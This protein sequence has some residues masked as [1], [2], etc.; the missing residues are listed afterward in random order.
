MGPPPPASVCLVTRARTSDEMDTAEQRDARIFYIVDI[1]DV[2]IVDVDT[3]DCREWRP[4]VFLKNRSKICLH[5]M[6]TSKRFG[7]EAFTTIKIPMYRV[8]C[9]MLCL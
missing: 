6:V 1:L 7:Y 3:V 4:G 8:S 5:R 2:D 9:C